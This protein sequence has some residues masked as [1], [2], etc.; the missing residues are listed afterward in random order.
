MHRFAKELREHFKV[1]S[2]RVKHETRDVRGYW[3]KDLKR[4]FD[5]FLP[6][7]DKP[8]SPDGS[9]T[10]E[11]EDSQTPPKKGPISGAVGGSYSESATYRR[12]LGQEEVAPR[13]LQKEQ[14]APASNTPTSSCE[15]SATYK[16]EFFPSDENSFLV[17]DTETS[18]ELEGRRRGRKVSRDALDP[19]KCELRILSAATPS[20]NVIVHDFRKGP[21]PNELRAAVATT[22]LIA[23]GAAF[24]LAVL[25]SNAIKTSRNVFC[26]LTASRLLTAGLR[27]SNDLGAVVKRHLGIELAK[28]LG[29][30]DWGGMLLTDDQLKYCEND[31]RHLHAL[32]DALQNKLA[33]PADE[34]GDGAE[35]VDLLRVAA[36]EMSLIP[37]VVDIRRRGIKVDRARLEQ[38]L[39]SYKA[40][41]KQRASLLRDT[42]GAPRL[43]F[44]SQVQLL[45]VLRAEGLEIEDTS[46]E[47]L[48]ASEHPVAGQILEYRKFAGLCTTM[49]GWRKNLDSD[50]RLYPPLNPLGADTGRFSCKDP[51]LLGVSREPEIRSCFVADDGCVFIESDYANIEMRIAAWFAQEKH[52]LEVFR[53]GGD[54]HGETAARVLGNRQAR[55]PAKPIN[56]GCLYGGGSERL[57]ISARTNFG[58]EFTSEQ[59][60][61]YHDGFFS[62]WPNLRRWHGAARDLSSELTYGATVFGRRRWADPEDHADQR[63]WNRFQ[64]A[65]NFEVQGAGADALKLALSRLHREFTGTPTRILLPLHDAILVQ[66]PRKNAQAVAEVLSETMREAFREILGSDF[67]VAVETNIS[68]RWGEKNS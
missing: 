47:T 39:A 13:H 24:D 36:L 33:N 31:V 2:K 20:G 62:A 15:N 55:Q 6:P 35:G 63:D 1:H 48:S 27:D 21:L 28:E 59:S 34:N 61:Q 4:H 58:I 38:T 17:I 67:P 10:A 5:S 45:K 46:K 41:A 60:K 37:M 40:T 23:H 56:F 3:L 50:N 12:H 30:A 54:I 53:N 66:T 29:G 51:N 25:E 22:P 8:P 26:T 44:S 57:R 65:T 16:A 42:L 43:N 9:E 68:T 52:M 14:V 11:K 64:L 32:R 7:E 19:R 18:A 49:E